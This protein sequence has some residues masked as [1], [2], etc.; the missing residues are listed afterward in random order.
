MCRETYLATAAD[1]VVIHQ[2]HR[3]LINDPRTLDLILYFMQHHRFP[4]EA[5]RPLPAPE[6]SV[7]GSSIPMAV[8]A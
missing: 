4:A 3:A 5:R 1:R 7:L 8:S 2:S 6:K